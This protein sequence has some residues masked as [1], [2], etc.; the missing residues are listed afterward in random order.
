MPSA[1]FP[2]DPQPPVVPD[3]ELESAELQE[4]R[5]M[6]QEVRDL[7]KTVGGMRKL[8]KRFLKN[9]SKKR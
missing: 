6:R 7:A 4:I 1:R 8:V 9:R 3:G 2:Y 5:A